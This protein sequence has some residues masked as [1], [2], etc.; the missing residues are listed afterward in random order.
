MYKGIFIFRRF[1]PIPV[2]YGQFFIIACNNA[3]DETCFYRS[4]L[5]EDTDYG[6]IKGRKFPVPAG[7]DNSYSSGP[8]PFLPLTGTAHHRFLE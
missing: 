4:D 3:I 8:L 1:S 7:Y 2:V 5:Y 6:I